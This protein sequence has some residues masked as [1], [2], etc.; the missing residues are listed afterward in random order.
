MYVATITHIPIYN[1]PVHVCAST[2]MYVYLYVACVCT[3]VYHVN[4]HATDCGMHT[5]A[6]SPCLF[7]CVC[8]CVHL[9]VR[10]CVCVCVLT[11]SRQVFSSMC[12][13]VR[14]YF[15][16]RACMYLL[17]RACMCVCVICGMCLVVH[18]RTR[19]ME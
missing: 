5:R 8:V 18:I 7:V 14:V 4:L 9:S 12:A 16:V 10:V 3:F 11:R 13:C 19:R 1:M 6:C 15:C 2:C 17:V